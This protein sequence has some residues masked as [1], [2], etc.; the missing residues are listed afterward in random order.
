MSDHD[1]L[2][3]GRDRPDAATRSPLVPLRPVPLEDVALREEIE[4]LMDVMASVSDC[5]EH[6]TVEEVD[7]ALRLSGG[8]PSPAPTRLPTGSSMPRGAT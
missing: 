8:S 7:A 5:P 1:M 2:V 3:T 4:L 6:L